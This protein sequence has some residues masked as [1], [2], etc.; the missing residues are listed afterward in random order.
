MREARVEE[1]AG[2]DASRRVLDPP[3]TLAA[4]PRRS[5]V[6]EGREE[7]RV[8]G[9]REH[10]QTDGDA[11]G[12]ER[13]LVEVLL[14]VGARAHLQHPEAAAGIH[15]VGREG[16]TRDARNAGDGEDAL[17]APDAAG[18]LREEG[19]REVGVEEGAARAEGET[20]VEPGWIRGAHAGEDE[21]GWA[22]RGHGHRARVARDRQGVQRARGPVGAADGEQ[23][24]A[25]GRETEAGDR[26]GDGGRD[27]EGLRHG[28]LDRIRQRQGASG[29][30]DAQKGR[31]DENA[32]S[33]ASP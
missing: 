15:A 25:V 3:D 19:R 23:S 17:V 5:G 32:C 21:G 7:V 28:E 33:R 4:D 1:V 9:R 27:H 8:R 14:G 22:E 13:D 29:R 10:E 6:E 30:S 11:I 18:T 16:D 20:R 2:E 31:H 24:R 12:F 26:P